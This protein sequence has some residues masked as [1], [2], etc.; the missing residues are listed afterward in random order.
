MV[1]LLPKYVR[2]HNRRCRLTGIQQ[3]ARQMNPFI[4]ICQMFH[5][6]TQQILHPMIG[7][8][9]D[10]NRIALERAWNNVL[11]DQQLRQVQH[12]FIDGKQLDPCCKC[13]SLFSVRI[14]GRR[15]F[16][17]DLRGDKNL[18]P[19]RLR[20]EP[21]QTAPFPRLTIDVRPRSYTCTE[22]AR[23][24][25]DLRHVPI[26]SDNIISHSRFPLL[27]TSD[28]PARRSG[29]LTPKALTRI[30]PAIQHFLR[31][32]LPIGSTCVY[33]T[34]Y[35]ARHGCGRGRITFLYSQRNCRMDL[36]ALSSRSRP[37]SRG[38]LLPAGLRVFALRRHSAGQRD[39]QGKA[40]KG[41]K[42]GK[43]DK[44]KRRKRG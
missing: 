16:S 18:M 29:S 35:N 10:V 25:V 21:A 22:K 42:G 37:P 43:G 7:G 40:E 39:R 14:A 11:F 31:N 36:P 41:I 8:H 38:C 20:F 19:R 4:W 13:Q 17:H 27:V 1:F 6:P 24:K 30:R 44:Y 26:V 9:R 28:R 5:I 34:G 15:Q 33:K 2:R 23:L 32:P 12:L 3:D